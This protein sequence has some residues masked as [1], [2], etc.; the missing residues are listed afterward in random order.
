MSF[1]NEQPG[2][3]FNAHLGLP[4]SNQIKNLLINNMAIS[5]NF[6]SKS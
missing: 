6:A 3:N 4:Q 1:A 5:G 2:G